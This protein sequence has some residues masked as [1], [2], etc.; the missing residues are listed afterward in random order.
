MQDSE[1]TRNMKDIR[2]SF[3]LKAKYVTIKNN[4]K[5][6]KVCMMHGLWSYTKVLLKMRK[7]KLAFG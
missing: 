3:K 6:S 2:I 7:F 4:K 1:N 5:S